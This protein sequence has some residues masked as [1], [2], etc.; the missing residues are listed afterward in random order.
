MKRIITTIITGLLLCSGH[1]AFAQDGP[2]DNSPAPAA[3]NPNQAQ[4]AIDMLKNMP[5][6]QRQQLLKTSV[7]Q[8]QS[9]TPEQLKQYKAMYDSLPPE[10]K[11][12]LDS[13]VQQQLQAD[14]KLKNDAQQK[15]QNLTP[16]QEKQ[17]ED[18]NQ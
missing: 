3:A 8:V 9:L 10:E 5:P 13:Q 11:Q 7:D 2:S 18:S 17:L 1:A 4:E 6:E 12:Q 15:L 14:P 16:A